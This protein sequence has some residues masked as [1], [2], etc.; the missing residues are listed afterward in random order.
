M[1]YLLPINN[2][3]LSLETVKKSIEQIEENAEI[4]FIH[5]VPTQKSRQDN[6]L[7]NNQSKRESLA[8]TAITHATEI[9][10]EYNINYTTEIFYAESIPKGIKEAEKEY[11][12]DAVIMSHRNTRPPTKSIT[13]N[14]LQETETPVTVFTE[15]TL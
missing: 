14:V 5:C 1:K 12:P 15:K 9:C 4:I 3:K 7:T 13:K 2:S 11:E 10:E 8:D 6:V